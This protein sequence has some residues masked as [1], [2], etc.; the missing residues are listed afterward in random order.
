MQGAY[1]N[2]D[3]P[4]LNRNDVEENSTTDAATTSTTTPWPYADRYYTAPLK[5]ANYAQK[6]A[7]N[8]N[9][10]Y[11]LNNNNNNINN[12]NKADAVARPNNY[13]YNYS[14]AAPTAIAKPAAAFVSKAIDSISNK[15]DYY[16]SKA[17]KVIGNIRDM[18]TNK[19]RPASDQW[20]NQ[21]QR[22]MRIICQID[23]H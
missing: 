1:E 14:P 6:V 10:Y 7:A 2:G 17:D 19:Q 18:A 16:F 23:L 22:Y 4:L 8:P 12:N 9:N 21:V 13:Y 3:L 11:Y 15:L 20:S 5:N